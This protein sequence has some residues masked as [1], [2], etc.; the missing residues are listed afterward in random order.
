MDF[1]RLF[2]VGCHFGQQAV[3]RNANVYGKA[4]LPVDAVLDGL[5]RLQRRAK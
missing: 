3:G 4:Q 1:I 2:K 5:R